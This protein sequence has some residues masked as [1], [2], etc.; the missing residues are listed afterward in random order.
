MYTDPYTATPLRGELVFADLKARLLHGDFPV[1]RR[2]GEERLAT[3]LDV[4]RTPVREALHRLHAEGLVVRHPEGGFLPAVPDV[5]TMRT[6]YEVRVGLEIQALRRPARLGLT[7]DAPLLLGLREE[8]ETLRDDVPE[9]G[10]DFVVFDESFHV[11]L[12]EAAGNAVIVEFLHTINDRIRIV[13]MQDFLTS[14]R[15]EETI[16]Q[17]LDIVDAVLSGDTEL[18]VARFDDHLSQSLAVVEQ[19]T[20]Q[21]I[22]LMAGREVDAT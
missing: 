17:H 8:W 19:R 4:S 13:R 12:A 18:A 7:H 11:G 10:P 16:T 9:Q 6:L 2:L 15:I 5:T 14:D 20:L 22:A 1:G 3:L 21:A